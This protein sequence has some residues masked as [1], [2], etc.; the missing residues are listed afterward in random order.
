MRMAKQ[1]RGAG[2]GGLVKIKTLKVVMV[3]TAKGL[4]GGSVEVVVELVVVVVTK[5]TVMVAI[6]GR[7]GADDGVGEWW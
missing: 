5:V 6:G 1:G 4:V 7:A 3:V 2:G